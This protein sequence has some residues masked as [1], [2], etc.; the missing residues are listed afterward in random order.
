MEYLP[1]KG[2]PTVASTQRQFWLFL[3]LFVSSF[4]VSVS[5]QVVINE[6]LPGG[7]VE[8]LNTGSTTVDVSSYWLCDFPAYQRISNS[9][10]DC[11]NMMLAP[12][13]ILTVNN[14]NTIDNDD[15]EM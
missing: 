15:G 7:T 12:G 8:L 11:G 6:V 9:D 10:L 1:S 3:L 13:E 14:F 5:A 2:S 4:P